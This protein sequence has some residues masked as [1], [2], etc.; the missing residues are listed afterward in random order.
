MAL[1][2]TWVEVVPQGFGNEAFPVLDRVCRLHVLL[3]RVWRC[4]CTGATCCISISRSHFT[5]AHRSRLRRAMFPLDADIPIQ[6]GQPFSFSYHGANRMG[7][8]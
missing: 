2:A 3:F 6:V 7:M 5:P 4:A 1:P 8:W